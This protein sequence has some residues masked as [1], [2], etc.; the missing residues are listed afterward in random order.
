MLDLARKHDREPAERMTRRQHTVDPGHRI[1]TRQRDVR[2]VGEALD[3]IGDVTELDVLREKHAIFLSGPPIE[4]RGSNPRTP[5][6]PLR[7][8]GTRL[9]GLNVQSFVPRLVRICTRLVENRPIPRRTGW[10]AARLI[11]RSVLAVEGRTH[12][13]TDR[14]GSRC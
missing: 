7:N 10:R 2:L 8:R 1:E 13:T 12:L 6:N 11:P 4:K 14:P 3:R 5:L 9:P